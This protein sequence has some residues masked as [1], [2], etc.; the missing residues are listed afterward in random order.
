MEC[1][2]HFEGDTSQLELIPP[3]IAD[4]NG[5]PITDN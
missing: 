5:V 4:G 2:T 3:H 1:R